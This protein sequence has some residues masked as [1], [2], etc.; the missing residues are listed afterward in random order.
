MPSM[1]FS[2]WQRHIHAFGNVVGHKASDPDARF[3]NTN[4]LAFL[5]G[6]CRPLIGDPQALM[7]VLTVRCFDAF[8]S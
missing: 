1:P 5:R 3:H 6:A 8:F 7:A 4:R 2:R